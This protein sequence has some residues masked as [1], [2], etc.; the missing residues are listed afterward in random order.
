MIIATKPEYYFD[1]NASYII[2]GGLGGLGRSTAKW[3]ASRGA[4]NLILLSR[5]GA[6]SNA[7]IEFVKELR[8]MEVHVDASP[9]DVTDAKSLHDTLTRCARTMPPVK[10]CIQ[11]T[12]Q[13][14]DALFEKMTFEDWKLSLGPK[15]QGTW[16][17]H[18]SL[19][20]GMDFFIC[21]SSVS[22][23][24]GSAGTANYAAGNTFIDE[25]VRY[26][27]R[28]G[29]KAISLDLGWMT[30]V[31]VVAESSYLSNSIATSGFLQPISPTE[32]HALLDH[33]C[34]PNLKIATPT[35]SQIVLG[36][37]TPVGMR[38]KGLPEPH[39]MG[40]KL[41]SHLQQADSSASQSNK[42]LNYGTLF[43]DADSVER[44]AQIIME[45][46]VE[47]LSKALSISIEDIDKLKPLHTYGVDSL[48]AVGLRN[49]F[50]REMD[51][52]L[53]VFDIMGG[54]DF[55]TV[56]ETVARKSQV[57]GK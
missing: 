9:C 31:G 40:G 28:Q 16:N 4:K 15:V 7:A 6:R 32:F 12:M 41:F 36:L 46:L 18:S 17:L 27:V 37:E 53:A 43:R 30:S 5:S 56:S 33:Y 49:Y 52:D 44:K 21:F 26:R 14:R 35:T 55:A 48:L 25:F 19:P 13:L 34:N 51:V 47:K 45:C 29:E 50:A 20:S 57:R 38:K 2:A 10:G 54:S 24:N 8:A 22:G 23:I 39:W 11:A 42:A 3:M 1:S